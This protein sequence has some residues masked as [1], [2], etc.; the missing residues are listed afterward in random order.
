MLVAAFA[1][2]EFMFGIL[3]MEITRKIRVLGMAN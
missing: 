2:L 3:E 1:A